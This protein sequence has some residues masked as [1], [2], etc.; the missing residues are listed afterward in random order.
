MPSKRRYNSQ[1]KGKFYR[2]NQNIKAKELRVIDSNGDQI[3]VITHQEALKK[4]KDQEMDLIEIAPNA[5]PPVAKIADFKK[6][7]YQESKKLASQA[8]KAK[9]GGLK[10]VRLTPFMAEGDLNV[11]IK[12]IREFVQDKHKVK[13]SVRFTRRQMRSKSQGYKL[14]ESVVTIMGDTIKVDQSPKFAG[15]QLAMT[16]TGNNV[17]KATAQ[18][19]TNKE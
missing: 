13:V 14:L 17:A 9:V 1:T 15:M 11:R 5:N 18:T 4:A 10:E 12:R 19:E 3:G 8:K 2:T 16:V 6:F 7:K